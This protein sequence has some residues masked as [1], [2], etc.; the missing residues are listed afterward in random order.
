MREL[1]TLGSAL[2]L[3]LAGEGTRS[4]LISLNASIGPWQGTWSSGQ[5]SLSTQAEQTGVAKAE[6]RVLRQQLQ[7]TSKYCRDSAAGRT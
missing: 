6:L 1:M 5:A 2:D 3:L 7:N 4:G